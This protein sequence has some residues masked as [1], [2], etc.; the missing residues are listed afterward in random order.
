VTEENG[1]PLGEWLRQRRE[2][3]GISLEQTE[4]D[5][6]IRIRYIEALETENFDS[7]PDPV[8]GRGFLRNYASYLDLDA[9]EASDRYSRL[10]A[11]PEPEPLPER[12]AEF[13]SPDAFRPVP[14]HD[15][16][17]FRARRSW[18]LVAA[19]VVAAALIAAAWWGY[20]YISRA[21]FSQRPTA[22]PTATQALA[23]TDLP[24]A[25]Q[26]ETASAA[27]TRTS[28]V[29][30]T[31]TGAAPV[32][33]TATLELSPTSSLTPSPSPSPSPP[34]YTGIFLELVF[35]DTSWIQI[36]VDG[37]R[38]FQGEL[39][40]DTY[41]SWYGEE[42]IELR[43]GNAG[44]VL[45]T[46]NGESLGPLGAPGEVVD[47]IFEKVDEEVTQA[48]VTPSS[49][50]E[51]TPAPTATASRTPTLEPSP[52]PAAAE[53]LPSETATAVPADTATASP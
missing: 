28:T 1:R 33:E 16:P 47:R 43:V 12:E 5:T 27:A 44:S 14:L 6:R 36:T 24:T 8:V 50:V 4:A 52:S 21:L 53:P 46:V 40:A 51:E 49:T 38:Q 42:R 22:T 31:S 23:S 29:P 41:R 9:A 18:F 19:L 37:V 2:E 39:E 10:V 30:P 13:T 26:T 48:T 17:G 3:L 25:T 34:V 20:P 15:M 32:E 7:L 45:V 11:P 35:T